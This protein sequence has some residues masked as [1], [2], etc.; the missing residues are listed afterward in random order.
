[1][2]LRL[3]WADLSP[4]PWLFIG[5]CV[6]GDSLAV[7]GWFAFREA[8]LYGMAGLPCVLVL[9]GSPPPSLLLQESNLRQVRHF[10]FVSAPLLSIVQSKGFQ[11]NAFLFLKSR[12]DY[13]SKQ[14]GE[15]ERY[16]DTVGPSQRSQAARGVGLLVALRG[17]QRAQR[18]RVRDAA[19]TRCILCT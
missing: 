4:R 11:G 8:S 12:I 18:G 3:C 17:R 14:K 6:I 1:M 13:H 5:G 19:R 10:R 2:C 15:R 7:L 16:P 9:F